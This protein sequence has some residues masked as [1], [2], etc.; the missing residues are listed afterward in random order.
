MWL[1]LLFWICILTLILFLGLG[2]ITRY[3]VRRLMGAA[4]LFEGRIAPHKGNSSPWSDAYFEADSWAS[5]MGFERFECLNFYALMD[6]EPVQLA[7]WKHPDHCRYLVFYFFME[8]TW[9]E[10]VSVFDNGE[11]L[12]TSS[13]RDSLMLPTPE[14]MYVQAFSQVEPDELLRRHCLSEDYIKEQ[15]KTRTVLPNKSL[16]ELMLKTIQNQI[17]YVQS[18]SFWYMN[19]AIW[20]FYRRLAF[21]GKPVA[22]TYRHQLKSI[23]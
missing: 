21:N 15:K 11:T 8:K 1:Q 20:Y 22:K 2:Y 13:Q 4:S 16:R 3:S 23:A 6:E 12:A 19:G 14:G 5:K 18:S 7:S 9:W 10:L 17:E